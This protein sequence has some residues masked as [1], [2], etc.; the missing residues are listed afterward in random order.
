MT[1][2]SSTSLTDHDL[3][4]LCQRHRD[5]QELQEVVR[6]YLR[7]KQMLE[8]HFGPPDS[9]LTDLIN[10]H[11]GLRSEIEALIAKNNT[12]THTQSNGKTAR[13]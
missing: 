2:A 3:K 11:E 6:D 5:D 7:V 4:A 12:T 8:S 13:T 9:F 10:T 1:L